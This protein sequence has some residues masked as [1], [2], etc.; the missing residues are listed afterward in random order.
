[1]K[2]TI[3]TVLDR[4][5]LLNNQKTLSIN[6]TNTLAMLRWAVEQNA[7][8]NALQQKLADLVSPEA[9]DVS[10]SNEQYPMPALT[11]QER[12]LCVAWCLK[13]LSSIEKNLPRYKNFIDGD[14]LIAIVKKDRLIYSVALAVLAENADVRADAAKDGV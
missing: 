8:A 7:R 4:I 1:M 12:Q 11:E 3:K 13:A 10:L 5:T 14:N 6:E 2:V 9:K